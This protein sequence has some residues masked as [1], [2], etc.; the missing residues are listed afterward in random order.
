[1]TEALTQSLRSA[2]AFAASHSCIT[3]A[4][5]QAILRAAIPALEAAMQPGE[6]EVERLQAEL[7]K[8]KQPSWFYHP[9]YTETCQFSPLEVIDD[10]YDPEPG[11]HVFEIECARPLPSIWCAVHCLTDDEREAMGTG[12]RFVATEHDTE[13]EARAAIAAMKGEG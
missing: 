2:L 11:K 12:E 9:D 13:E 10:Y 7:S 5:E 3:S 4:Q 8:A 1:M 6:G